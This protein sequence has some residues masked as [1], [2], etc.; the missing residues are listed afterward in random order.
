MTR[1][2]SKASGLFDFVDFCLS[3]MLAKNMNMLT[4][5]TNFIFPSE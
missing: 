2:F 1:I 3:G 4:A 5:V